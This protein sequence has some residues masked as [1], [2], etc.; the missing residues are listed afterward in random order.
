MKKGPTVEFLEAVGSTV[1][2][3]QPRTGWV[4]SDCPFGPWKHENGKSS[5]HV[6]GIR[7]TPGDAQANCFACGWHG[8][9]S[10]IVLELRR[11]V[12]LNPLATPDFKTAGALALK[13]QE[14]FELELDTPD[15]EEMLF[16]PKKDLHVFPNWWLESFPLW[17]DVPFAVQYLAERN[18]S[19]E[20]ADFL[21][22]RADSNEKRVCF[23]VH[24]FKQRLVGFHG[25]SVLEKTDLRYR[26]YLQSGKHNQVVWLGERW[27]DFEQPIVVVEGPFD[28]AAVLPVYKN[29]VSPLF[30]NPSFEKLKRMAPAFEWIT[31]YDRG[32]GGDAGRE[33]VTEALGSDYLIHHLQP[34][35]GVKDPGSMSPSEIYDT[36]KVVLPKS[37]LAVD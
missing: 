22:I 15:I 3:S 18:V 23:P 12:K 9:L 4:I 6:F 7:T 21:Q 30:A 2:K 33:K 11:L 10:D 19:K 26:M 29:V 16:G 25:R 13:A 34:P 27:V 20:T 37:S 14:E 17:Q 1:P 5:D 8:T 31:L 36:L 28:L 35:D 24:D 32:K